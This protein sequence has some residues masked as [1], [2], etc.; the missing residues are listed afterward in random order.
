MKVS[1]F[2][3]ISKRNKV[4]EV[5]NDLMYDDETISSNSFSA[6]G[7]KK[8][9]LEYK[10]DIKKIEKE[11]KKRYNIDLYDFI[12]EYEDEVFSD[13]LFTQQNAL[14]DTLLYS[15][16]KNKGI[17][18]GIKLSETDAVEHLIKYRYSYHNY[19]M[20][21]RYLLQ[22]YGS[23][24]K[25][26]YEAANNLLE[27]L[28]VPEYDD[29]DVAYLFNSNITKEKVNK[30]KDKCSII[31]HDDNGSTIFISIK[32]LLNLIFDKSV[33][34]SEFEKAV[35]L[36]LNHQEIEHEFKD[37]ILIAYFGNPSKNY[38]FDEIKK[39]LEF[40]F[41]VNNYNV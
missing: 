23:M 9:F 16:N 24:K 5:I 32:L 20:G 37:D 13:H 11:L 1:K 22:S 29:G 15:Y 28:I 6:G 27:A 18:Y 7:Y 2:D 31:K 38:N 39:E 17:L 30:N 36:D 12:H 3:Y 40:K 4:I 34:I 10:E 14:Y 8:R 21:K 41:D 35:D 26:F 25:Y 19:D 33:S